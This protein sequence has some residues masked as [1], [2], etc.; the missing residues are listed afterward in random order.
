MYLFIFTY[1]LHYYIYT[2]SPSVAGARLVLGCGFW[3]TQLCWDSES[4][5]QYYLTYKM[6]VCD[7]APTKSRRVHTRSVAPPS[8]SVA[9]P[10]WSVAP[11]SVM[12]ATISEFDD[13]PAQTKPFLAACVGAAFP[14]CRQRRRRN[15][16]QSQQRSPR[17][18]TVKSVGVAEVRALLHAPQWGG[19]GRSATGTGTYLALVVTSKS[20]RVEWPVFLGAVWL[21]VWLPS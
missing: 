19:M 15:Y 8:W 14:W 18:P 12:R 20:R 6:C 17:W 4:R 9:P 2:C 16:Y 5:K 1:M 10:S 3:R 13:R 21:W 7:S 11:P